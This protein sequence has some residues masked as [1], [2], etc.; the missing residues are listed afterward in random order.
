MAKYP[1]KYC[2]ALTEADKAVTLGENVVLCI[3]GVGSLP[4][5]FM[6]LFDVD[7]PAAQDTYPV[8]ISTR[9]SG[10]VH[11]VDSNLNIVTYGD[12]VYNSVYLVAKI[13]VCGSDDCCSNQQTTYF[14]L[15][16]S[17]IS[18]GTAANFF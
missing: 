13:N 9:N 8:Y 11:L 4:Q 16:G 17:T 7:D 5:T 12:L 18:G 1:K 14:Q 10:N 15:V 6:L 3:K 2:C